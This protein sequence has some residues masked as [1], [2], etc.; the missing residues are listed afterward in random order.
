MVRQH[1]HCY[2]RKK[3]KK[4]KLSSDMQESTHKV[5]K[6][7]ASQVVL[8]RTQLTHHAT[9]RTPHGASHLVHAMFAGSKKADV[10][11]PGIVG[12]RGSKVLRLRLRMKKVHSP[13]PLF[14]PHLPETALSDAAF[15]IKPAARLPHRRQLVQPQRR[16]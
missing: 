2:T 9:R 7:S 16:A 3:K 15:R 14:I 10:P 6:K 4:S 13:R 8:G 12:M 11:R 1:P 5:R